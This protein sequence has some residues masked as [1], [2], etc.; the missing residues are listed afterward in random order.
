MVLTGFNEF[1]VYHN[2]RLVDDLDYDY[3]DEF[4]LIDNKS[5]VAVGEYSITYGRFTITPPIIRC[6]TNNP[7]V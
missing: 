6:H 4:L 7:K 1:K 2:D 5:F 3:I